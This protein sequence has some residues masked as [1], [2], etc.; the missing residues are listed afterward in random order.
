MLEEE[1]HGG[2]DGYDDNAEMAEVDAADAPGT[3]AA[4]VAEQR[5]NAS[6]SRRYG[7]RKMCAEESDVKASAMQ[8]ENRMPRRPRTMSLKWTNVAWQKY[9]TAQDQCERGE[10]GGVT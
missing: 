10:G 4:C 9:I 1:T 5:Q 3:S 2:E 6:S 8:H 7:K